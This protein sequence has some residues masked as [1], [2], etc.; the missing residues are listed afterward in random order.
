MRPLYRLGSRNLIDAVEEFPEFGDFTIAHSPH[1]GSYWAVRTSIRYSGPLAKFMPILPV[2][3]LAAAAMVR[4]TA[5]ERQ[6]WITPVGL[7]RAI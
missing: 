1:S 6:T 3:A 4:D 5:F 7:S 2:N